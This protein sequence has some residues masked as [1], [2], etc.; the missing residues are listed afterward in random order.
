MRSRD[1]FKLSDWWIG[2]ILSDLFINTALML[3][4]VFGVL[5]KP[6]TDKIIR[7]GPRE[8]GG[9]GGRE[10]AREKFNNATGTIC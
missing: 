6:V 10:G 8:G 7:E 4:H 9:Q 3:N 2:F 1:C 5:S